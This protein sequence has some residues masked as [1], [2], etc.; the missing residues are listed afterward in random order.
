MI[1]IGTKFQ[2]I[3]SLLYKSNTKHRIFDKKSKV[4]FSKYFTKIWHE[5]ITW[6]ISIL[7]WRNVK[8]YYNQFKNTRSFIF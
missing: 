7:N 3:E 8:K 6:Y 4:L 5:F 1:S 2:H